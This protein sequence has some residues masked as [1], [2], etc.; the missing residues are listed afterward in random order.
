VEGRQNG[1]ATS[2]RR[3]SRFAVKKIEPV[4]QAPGP[5]ETRSAYA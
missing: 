5:E 2:D 3:M 1:S 4:Q